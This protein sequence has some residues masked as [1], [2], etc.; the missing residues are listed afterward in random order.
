MTSSSAPLPDQIQRFIFDDTA[1]R[2]E[3]VQLHQSYQEVLIRHEYPPAIEKLLGELLAATALL[4][5]TVKLE[6]TLT[7]EARGQGEVSLLM[8]ECNTGIQGGD[9]LR[10]IAR[11]QDEPQGH[12]LTELLKGGQLVIT[13]DPY[14]GK[15]YQGIVALD[16]ETLTA[17]LEGYFASSEQL[18]TRLWL[19]ADNKSAAGLLLQK[20]PEDAQNKDPDAWT[21]VGHLAATVTSEELLHLEQQQLLH[22]LFHEEDLRVFEP[23]LLKFGCTCSRE[24]I[25]NALASLGEEELNSAIAEQGKITTQCHFC[26][27]SYVFSQKDLPEILNLQNKV[28]PQGTKLH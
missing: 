28:A 1:V 9:Q 5:A 21:R 22:R 14:E 25:S 13:L 15:R 3:L 26:N 23:K 7:L 24:R 8:A 20:L 11:Y 16:Q 4:T 2:G 19:A 6:G 27:T 10:A 17:C 18:P 12:T